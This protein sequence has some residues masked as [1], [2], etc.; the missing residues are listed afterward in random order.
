M[1]DIKTP[2]INQSSE[3]ITS[4]NGHIW[5]IGDIITSCHVDLCSHKLVCDLSHL[6]RFSNDR[7]GSST[8][9]TS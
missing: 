5:W 6:S 7:R 3:R 4:A 2:Y 9:L 8:E 1:A